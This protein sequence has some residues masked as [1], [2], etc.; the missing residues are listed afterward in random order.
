MG[1]WEVVY[2]INLSGTTGGT[3]TSSEAYGYG[4]N[5]KT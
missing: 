5:T 3:G 4:S 1:S 2:N